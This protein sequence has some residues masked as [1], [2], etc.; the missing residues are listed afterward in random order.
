[1]RKGT[2]TACARKS[3]LH[4]LRLNRQVAFHCSRV[5]SR[6]IWRELGFAGFPTSARNSGRWHD[7]LGWLRGTARA[8]ACLH[9][10]LLPYRTTARHSFSP[11]RN[12]RH[13]GFHHF[14]GG[15]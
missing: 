12:E 9:K 10:H 3:I 7:R 13:F 15:V 5:I 1:M 2:A 14:F 11:S 4:A 6:A 8:E